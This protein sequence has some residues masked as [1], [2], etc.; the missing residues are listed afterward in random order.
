MSP[1]GSDHPHLRSIDIK[2]NSEPWAHPF[3]KVV[4]LEEIVIPTNIA[5]PGV[6]V[7]IDNFGTDRRPQHGAEATDVFF[8]RSLQ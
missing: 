6:P 2:M 1:V 3:P 8:G 4:D 5:L 7:G